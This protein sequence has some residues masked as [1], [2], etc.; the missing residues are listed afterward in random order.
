MASKSVSLHPER[1]G[2]REQGMSNPTGRQRPMS[3]FMIG[4]Y[5]RPQMTSISSILVRITGLALIAGI[6]GLALPDRKS[7]V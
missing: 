2:T 7:V 3:P 4:P 6:V 1:H 5:Y